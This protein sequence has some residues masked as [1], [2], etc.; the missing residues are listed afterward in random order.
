MAAENRRRD[1]TTLYACGEWIVPRK[2]NLTRSAERDCSIVKL[3][4]PCLIWRFL[5]NTRRPTFH[6]S[7]VGSVSD[8][9]WSSL[10]LPERPKVTPKELVANCS[11]QKSPI[12]ERM[13]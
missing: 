9:R 5:S 12:F 1:A 6:A 2:R 7:D 13:M 3:R 4:I 10:L 8:A 11:A